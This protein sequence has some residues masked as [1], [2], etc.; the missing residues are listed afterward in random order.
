MLTGYQLHLK[1]T[2]SLSIFYFYCPFVTSSYP[3]DRCYQSSMPHY[4]MFFMLR[5]IT[6]GG[7]LN[8]ADAG[9][10][11]LSGWILH[12]DDA[13]DLERQTLIEWARSRLQQSI[14]EK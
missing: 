3:G 1:I 10:I 7:G 11:I 9:N 4:S 8:V 13:S 2:L 5:Y 12:Q 6:C 14:R